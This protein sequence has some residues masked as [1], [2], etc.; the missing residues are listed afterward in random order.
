MYI[1]TFQITNMTFQITN[2]MTSHISYFQSF[3]NPRADASSPVTVMAQECVMEG[4]IIGHVSTTLVN[5]DRMTVS[6]K[7][8]SILLVIFGIQRDKKKR[9]DKF[10]ISY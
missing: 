2:M 6:L 10:R 4:Q 8:I 1:V 5:A 3:Q 9:N 7:L